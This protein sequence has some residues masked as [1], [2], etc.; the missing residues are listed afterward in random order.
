MG[1]PEKP[2]ALSIS[3]LVPRLMRMWRTAP[4][5]PILPIFLLAELVLLIVG[6]NVLGVGPTLLWLVGAF[7]VGFMLQR[8]VQSH[9]LLQALQRLQ[10][11]RGISG[12]SLEEQ[13][14]AL[15]AMLLM[16]ASLALMMPGFLTDAVALLLLVPPLRQLVA[17]AIIRRASGADAMAAPKASTARKAR[18]TSGATVDVD[19]IR[20]E[21]AP[22]TPFDH[23]VRIINVEPR[24]PRAS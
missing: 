18:R 20:P 21:D 15:D 10:H 17:T 16:L 4:G 22:P 9:G 23:K 11:R 5:L 13:R 1:P 6:G 7:V 2:G 8:R 24:S 19:V 12:E 3:G 14:V